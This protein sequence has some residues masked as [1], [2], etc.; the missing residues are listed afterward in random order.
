MRIPLSWLNELA[1]FGDDVAMLTAT[2]DDLGLVVEGVERTGEGLGDVVVAR[3]DEISA[4]EGADK[5]RAVKAFDG[6]TELS[7]VCGAKNFEVG[8]LV[9]LAPVGAVLPG[10]FEIAKR[11]M[12]GVESHGMLCS[13]AELELA[14]DSAGLM[15]L[16]GVEGAAPGQRLIDLLGLEP[17]VVFDISVEGNRPDAWS[18]LGVARDLAA[19][20]GL[21]FNPPEPEASAPASGTSATGV[22]AATDLCGRLAVA[23]I[24]GV[25]VGPSPAWIERR[26]LLAGMRPINNVV[27]ASNLV[28]LE[29]GQ[30]THP[31]DLNRVP[32]GGIVVRRAKAGEQL[33]TLD[34]QVRTLGVARP[35]VGGGEDD[36]VIAAATDEVLGAA[37]I[38]G[39]A[40]SEIDDATTTVLLEAAWFEPM[41]IARTSKALGLRTEA[42]A[43]FERGCDPDGITTSV[44]RF[45]DLLALSSPTA[46]LAGPVVVAEGQLPE[47]PEIT[48]DLAAMNQF[49]GSDLDAEGVAGLLA[50]RGFTCTTQ[51]STVLVHVPAS[52]SDV[53]PAPF[54]VADLYEEVARTAG[55]RAMAR[56]SPSW[57]QPGGLSARQQLRRQ[58]REICVG[59][60]CAEVWT[61]TVLPDHLAE[62]VP[63]GQE[64]IRLANPLAAGESTLRTGLMPGVLEAAQRNLEHQ[65]HDVALFE[66]GTVFVHPTAMAEARLE[67]TAGSSGATT[68]LPGERELLALAFAREDDDA[69]SAVV[70]WR[71]IERSLGLQPARLEPV[72]QGAVPGCHPTRSA[73]LVA[74]DGRTLGV[75]GEADPGLLEAMA[76]STP[77]LRRR[78]AWI[79]VDVDALAAAP[80]L[81]LEAKPVSR[82]PSASFDLAFALVDEVPAAALESALAQAA[83][84]ALESIRLFDVFRGGQLAEGSR[85][86]AFELRLNAP[87]RT[88]SESDLAE[89][90]A[91]CIAA[92]EALGATLR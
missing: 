87:D 7:I 45:V 80:R 23:V 3:V 1:P 30:P 2:L 51:G 21:P 52:R 70:A 77:E 32:G 20:L 48:I 67:R 73:A 39:G 26:L 82:F 35:G 31:Y 86:L 74:S 22:I 6:T 33:E 79:E 12:R 66:V 25:E 72:G 54:G 44:S 81:P 10:G 91:T 38:M 62:L 64:P 75:V 56:T 78:V 92:G 36:L 90:R 88:L 14:E 55:Y 17:D 9:P 65:R 69:R 59:L 58:L 8:D 40:S 83:G 85:S 16:S 5:V 89:L 15:I 84:D 41:A 28:M 13:A 61:A 68:A 19:R 42:S 63:S 57:P 49:L 76:I 24:E 37:G 27:D 29:R 34:G 60:G 18:V 53:R 43:R 71:L 4:I 47:A 11:K 50:P 46:A